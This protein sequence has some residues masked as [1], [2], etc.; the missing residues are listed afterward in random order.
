MSWLRARFGDIAPEKLHW[1]DLNVCVFKSAYGGE[2]SSP[3]VGVDGASDTVKVNEAP[4][5]VSGTSP[6][7]RFESK[8]VS[9][10]RM[11]AGFDAE[12]RV[13]STIAF[14][15]GT[16]EDPSNR[17]YGDRESDWVAGLQSPLAFTRAEV[18]ARTV[19]RKILAPRR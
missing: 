15:R 16:H 2:A 5:F 9:L 11:V 3:V 6:R 18:D 4:F 8:D 7:E 13:R 1:G 12:G 19:S 10:Y 17:H 14:A